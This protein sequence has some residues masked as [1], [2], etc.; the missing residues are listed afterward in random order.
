[1]RRA[2][3]PALLLIL[4]LLIST[5]GCGHAPSV[6][7]VAEVPPESPPPVFVERLG[8][9]PPG[10][11]VLGPAC[12]AEVG[13]APSSFFGD[14]LLVR[15]PPG[16]EGEQVPEQSPD[17]A[18]SNS[19]LAMGCEAGLAAS[20]FVD[21]HRDG[22][23]RGLAAHRER[24]FANLNFPKH[25]DIDVVKGS[26]EG[27]DISLVMSFPDH[28]VWGETQVYVRMTERYGR[29]HTIGFLTE[30]R[31]YHQLEPVFQASA[32]TMVILPD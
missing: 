7:P 25:R 22:S 20:V 13:D 19:P 6:S 15:L 31:K 23:K 9:A 24:L 18:R 29:I 27:D 28:P 30:R 32:T 16:V 8:A 10:V 21:S 3:A 11:V 5:L 14:R 2:F 17:F 4:P 12:P 1:M 26:D